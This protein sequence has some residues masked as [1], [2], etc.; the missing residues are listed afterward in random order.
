MPTTQ[1]D[2]DEPSLR[3]GLQALEIVSSI[4][5][6]DIFAL[7]PLFLYKLLSNHSISKSGV[8]LSASD[9]SWSKYS[10]V[11]FAC[12]MQNINMPSSFKLLALGALVLGAEAQYGRMLEERHNCPAAITQTVY[13]NAFTATVYGTSVYSTVT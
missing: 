12:S 1:S 6:Y 3:D 13:T 10:L 4:S 5:F 9:L 7:R 11:Y 8:T 2:T